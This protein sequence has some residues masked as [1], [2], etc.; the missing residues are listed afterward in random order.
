MLFPNWLN[1]ADLSRVAVVAGGVERDVVSLVCGPKSAPATIVCDAATAS[2]FFA[3]DLFEQAPRASIIVSRSLAQDCDTLLSAKT[4][5]PTLMHDSVVQRHLGFE[6]SRTSSKLRVLAG[7][8]APRTLLDRLAIRRLV[9]FT[10]A[11]SDRFLA[12]LVIHDRYSLLASGAVGRLA[13]FEYP[14]TE[15]NEVVLAG[16]GDAQVEPALDDVEAHAQF[17][18]DTDLAVLVAMHAPVVCDAGHSVFAYWDANLV[19]LGREAAQHAALVADARGALAMV[20]TGAV[21]R[22]A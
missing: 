5:R 1:Q 13:V 11:M 16:T 20:Q 22:A 9:Q 2:R 14:R 18:V 15:N 4:A 3:S 8:D 6:R 19:R 10:C 12:P 17:L 7:Y 21:Q